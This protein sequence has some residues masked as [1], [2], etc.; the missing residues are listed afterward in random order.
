MKIVILNAFY[1]P[2]EIGGAERSV[3]ILAEGL[4]SFGHEVSVLCLGQERV[5][6]EHN[7]VRVERLPIRNFYL[8]SGKG[9]SRSGLS[10]MVWHMRDLHNIAAKSDVQSILNKLRPDIMHTN[11]L[12]GFSTAVW[13]CGRRA[14]IP[15]LHTPRD[16]YLLCPKGTMMSCQ[17]ACSEP[18]KTCLPFAS[19]RRIAAENVDS[20]VGISQFI[21]NRHIENGFFNGVASRVIYNPFVPMSNLPPKGTNEYPVVGYLGRL[22]PAKGIELLLQSIGLIKLKFP[23]IR[24]LVGGVGT[25]DYEVKLRR[26]AEGLPVEFLGHIDQQNF[27]NRI[28]L[29]AVPSIWN[30]PLGRV[31]LEAY[32]S[33]VPVVATAVGGLPEITCAASGELVSDV[34]PIGFAEALQR[35]IERIKQD[36]KGIREA[37][38]NE[39]KKYS[40]DVVVRAYEAAYQDAIVCRSAL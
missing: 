16:F 33:G 25:E 37:A 29:L 30:E 39:A 11:N 32:A 17:R 7:G 20:V 6:D 8:P 13:G 21:L 38:L 22:D 23:R 1:F 27:F 28:D 4:V 31:V 19:T 36:P 26:A 10:K 5:S 12:S 15:V 24:L 3:R 18:C 2:D 34:S 35:M 40:P 9:E 14:G